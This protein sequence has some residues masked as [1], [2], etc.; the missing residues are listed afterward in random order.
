MEREMTA[1]IKPF[2]PAIMITTD[3]SP[4]GWGVVI[5]V[6][7]KMGERKVRG[8]WGPEMRNIHSNIKELTA[9]RLALQVMEREEMIGREGVTDILVRSDNTTV[10]YDLNRK[11]CTASAKE[12]MIKIMEIG[13]K[14]K[15]R[16]R[17]S[18]IP[19]VENTVADRLSR[20]YDS[21]DYAI[22]DDCFEYV[23]ATFETSVSI[24]LF[25]A[26]HNTRAER[27]YSFGVCE[28]SLGTD[29]LAYSWK[30]ERGTAYAFPPVVLIEKVLRKL[31]E[32]KGTMIIIT[33]Q[34]KN[35]PWREDLKRMTVRQVELGKISDFAMRGF[36]VP[37][38]SVDH[39]GVWLASLVQATQ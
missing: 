27:F 24:D 25:A 19:G 7:G 37:A 8:N 31:Q 13:E 29:A 2:S 23:L 26:T 11:A 14:H 22:S 16:L 15:I 28:G 3:A 12:E 18:H 34:W 10:V 6:I 9:V 39:P 36:L 33:P 38:E 32:E 17:S 30:G 35:A 20:V 5:V 1:V 21:S 4:V